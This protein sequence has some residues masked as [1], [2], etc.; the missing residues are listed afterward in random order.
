MVRCQFA[1]LKIWLPDG[2]FLNVS[3]ILQESDVYKA[4]NWFLCVWAMCEDY[5][6]GNSGIVII[7]KKI[8]H[9][10]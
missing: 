6:T 4:M 7:G 3:L 2:D 1:T 5:K 10:W 8:D 9:L